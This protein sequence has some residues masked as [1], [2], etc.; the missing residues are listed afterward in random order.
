M[1]EILSD[2]ADLSEPLPR[3]TTGPRPAVALL[4]IWAD[5]IDAIADAV[6]NGP[7][8]GGGAGGGILLVYALDD[9]GY[10]RQVE[11]LVNRVSAPVFPID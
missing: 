4:G 7:Q 10:L 2:P 6:A 5:R 11:V 8:P 3:F 1:S 9:G